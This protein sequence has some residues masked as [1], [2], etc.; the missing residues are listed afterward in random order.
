MATLCVQAE[1]WSYIQTE[2]WGVGGKREENSGAE[3]TL[4]KYSMCSS[5]SFPA[6]LTVRF[7]PCDILASELSVEMTS[8]LEQGH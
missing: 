1:Y 6:F 2:G 5:P 4:I 7:D 8:L 3:V